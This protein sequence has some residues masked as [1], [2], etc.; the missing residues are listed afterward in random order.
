MG[1]CLWIGSYQAY[2]SFL[3]MPIKNMGQA[4]ARTSQD[5]LLRGLD[6]VLEK[7]SIIDSVGIIPY[8]PYP[9]Y[10][11]K[12]VKREE[13][14][15][16]N[17]S[18][19]V[20]AEYLNLKYLN[21][22]TREKALFAE[23][24]LWAKKQLDGVDT[25]FVYAPSVGRMK[26]ALWLRKKF[27]CKI[28]VVIPDI[29][30]NI[31]V[32]ADKIVLLAKKM[33]RNQLFNQ[34]KKSDGWVLYSEYMAEFYKLASNQ[35]V[36]VEGVL[37]ENDIT[38]LNNY[39]KKHKDKLIFM[40]SGSLD[41]CRGIREILGAFKKIDNPN[42]ELWFAGTGQC[43]ELIKA[44]MMKDCR[45]KHCG[46][47]FDRNIMLEMVKEVDILLHTRYT[48]EESLTK[49]SFPSKIFEYMASGNVV[50]S[51]R[52]DSIPEEYNEYLVYID[53]L[54]ED[55]LYSCMSALTEAGREEL[56][57]LGNKAKDFIVKNKNS[58]AQA[59]KIK[60]LMR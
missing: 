33:L 38:V 30:E 56:Y 5:G 58:K 13:W 35:W 42:I 20:S 36:L 7:E 37:N 49:Y 24:K 6:Q 54:S 39:Q 44:E 18:V 22:Y 40:Y 14:S 55:S 17:G 31:F 60:S 48:N 9:I 16:H 28:I 2:E 23:V 59:N 4:S 57:T 8:A 34:L 26:A 53:E 46:F 45:I 25:V 43:D 19:D 52:M 21:Y 10:P 3:N 50:V 47:I 29:P 27:G 12:K 11:Q 41:Y 51:V 1:K 32:G 15:R